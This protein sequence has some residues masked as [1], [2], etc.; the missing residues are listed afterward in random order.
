MIIRNTV[1]LFSFRTKLSCMV[2]ITML[3]GA[4]GCSFLSPSSESIT[5]VGPIGYKSD[6]EKPR[7][8]GLEVPPDLTQLQQDNRYTV[9]G[10]QGSA[11][12]SQYMQQQQQLQGPQQPV[13]PLATTTPDGQVREAVQG[14]RIVR[15][16]SQRWLMADQSPE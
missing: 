15:E 16:G 1:S 12:A 14:M 11:S 6:G 3:V 8:R 2:C 9:P 5:G 10:Q 7:A 13:A 4:S